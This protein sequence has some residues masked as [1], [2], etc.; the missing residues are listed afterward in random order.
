MTLSRR[1]FL[2]S[3]LLAVGAGVVG[4]GT[5]HARPVLA[6]V[7]DYSA[8][9]PSGA[10][11]RAAGYQGAMRYVSAPRPGAEWMNAKPIR[12]PEA[13][14]FAAHNLAVASV[15]QFGVGPTADWKTGA[16][17]ATKHVPLAID[18]HIR[19][20]GPTGRPIYMAVD[21]N[22]T[23]S[24]YE[25]QIRPFLKEA[26]RLLRA[27]GYILGVYGNYNVIDWCVADRLGSYYWMHDWGSQG[28]LHPQAHIHQ[29]PQNKQVT[30]DGVQCD[31]NEVYAS[32]W[33]QWTPGLPTVV[34]PDT[35]SRPGTHGAGTTPTAP[36]AGLPLEQ[37][38]D[39][40]GLTPDET[41]ALGRAGQ[42]LSKLLGGGSSF[43]S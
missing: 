6:R 11:V 17:G 10:A 43:S 30:V 12:R 16:A 22:P 18:F 29:L 33:G 40:V 21:A 8:N 4:A 34:L 5:A 37:V 41:A 2:A 35:T 27:K 25:Q 31:V 19:A 15:Y 20:G 38:G 23:R 3:T 14:D 42:A 28:R 9:V 36:D 7:L 26:D 39:L 32:D 13:E 24:E 1:H